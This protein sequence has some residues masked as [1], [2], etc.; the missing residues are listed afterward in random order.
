[1]FHS[2]VLNLD[3]HKDTTRNLDQNLLPPTGKKYTCFFCIK[4]FQF[5]EIALVFQYYLG[6]LGLYIF[7]DLKSE[8]IKFTQ[9]F[10][11]FCYFDQNKVCLHF[12]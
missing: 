8:Q 1:M 9:F 6:K 11:L 2:H 12:F 5:W 4:A 3:A 10:P 7:P